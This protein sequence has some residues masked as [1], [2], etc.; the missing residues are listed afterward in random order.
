M[1]L[2]HRPARFPRLKALSIKAR[3]LIVRAAANFKESEWIC[4]SKLAWK[5]NFR[6]FRH[7]APETNHLCSRNQNGIIRRPQ[8]AWQRMWLLNGAEKKP[9]SVWMLPNQFNIYFSTQCSGVIDHGCICHQHKPSKVSSRTVLIGSSWDTR[10]P[11]AFLCLQTPGGVMAVC[12]RA[13]V[14]RQS[15]SSSDSPICHRICSLPT[16]SNPKLMSEQ[17]IP[18]GWWILPASPFAASDR[19]V[20]FFPFPPSVAPLCPSHFHASV[21]YFFLQRNISQ[22]GWA[23]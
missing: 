4:R 22:Q 17:N 16:G 12:W 11:R 21:L 15:F 2:R 3:C 8:R 18:A 19:G 1:S 6:Q 7:Q 9:D 14:P 10:S 23:R 5:T 20:D 13:N